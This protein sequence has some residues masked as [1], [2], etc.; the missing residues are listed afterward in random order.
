ME[1]SPEIMRF[2]RFEID[3]VNRRLASDG[4]DIDLGSRY[5]DALILLAS[6][7][8]DLVTKDRFMDEVWR[9]IPVTDEALTQCI[10]TLRRALGDDAANPRLIATVPK[11]GYR[12]LAEVEGAVR[13]SGFAATA[14]NPAAARS[15][16]MAG[17]TTLG[18]LAAGLIGGLA[19]GALATSGGASSLLTIVLLTAALAVLG[20]GGIGAG[21]GLAHLWRPNA[22]W[23]LPLGGLTGGALVGALG[24]T[25]GRSGLDALT[26][27][28]PLQAMGLYEGAVLGLAAGTALIAA[29]KW[30]LA[31][32]VAIPLALLAG[33]LAGMIVALS[34][35][36]M[37]GETLTAIEAG[38]PASQIDMDRLGP[39][40]GETGFY[41][42]TRLATAAIEGAVFTACLVGANLAADRD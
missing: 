27:T 2:D 33:A 34:G 13:S 6:N 35:G 37:Y 36:W 10:R 5:L 1:S 21:M 15:S 30:L 4:E 14:R 18:G 19:Y 31:G 7:P 41:M 25:L 42:L 26:G 22:S 32:K 16:R 28:A 24:S 38:F 3:L 17:S 20:A 39:I 11:H 23:A 40:F 8:G 12:F 29:R 9:G